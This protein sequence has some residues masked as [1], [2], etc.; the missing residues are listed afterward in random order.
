MKDAQEAE[1]CAMPWGLYMGHSPAV[2]QLHSGCCT[3][4]EL[5]TCPAVLQPWSHCAQ[6]HRSHGPG[7][8][9]GTNPW[10]APRDTAPGLLVLDGRSLYVTLHPLHAPR[11]RPLPTLSTQRHSLSSELY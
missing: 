5:P 2:G 8:E 6:G 4:Y 10:Q 1:G 3:A 7:F 9:K 11:L